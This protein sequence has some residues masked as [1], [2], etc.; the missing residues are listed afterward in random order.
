MIHETSFETRLHVNAE[1]GLPQTA[2]ILAGQGGAVTAQ[3]PGL[4]DSLQYA[5]AA[6]SDSLE[7]YI[8]L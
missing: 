4:L 5:Q 2:D 1:A 7:R 8:E 6:F 3:V